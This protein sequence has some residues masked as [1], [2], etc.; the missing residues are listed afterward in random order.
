MRILRESPELAL[1]LLGKLATELRV[2]EDQMVQRAVESV[3]QR[4]ARFLLWL[5]DAHPRAADGVRFDSVLRRED[6][7]MAIGTTPETLSRTLHDL[8]RRRII[9]LERRAIRVHEPAALRRLARGK[10]LD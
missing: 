4:T 6:I 2:S 5:H 7:A 9:S 1:R 10:G 8:K 3:P